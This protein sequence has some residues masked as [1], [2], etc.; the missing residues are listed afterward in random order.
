MVCIMYNSESDNSDDELHH[1]NDTIYLHPENPYVKPYVNSNMIIYNGEPIIADNKIITM[2]KTHIYLAKEIENKSCYIRWIII[3]EILITIPYCYNVYGVFLC[4]FTTIFNT[5]IVC[6]TFNYNKK[7]MKFYI[8]YEIIQLCIKIS[9]SIYITTI[10]HNKAYYNNLH[11][12]NTVNPYFILGS[13]IIFTCSHIPIIY[14]TIN[15]YKI[16]PTTKYI[17]SNSII[18]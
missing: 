15:Y 9:I 7:Y 6:C 14:Y 8:L 5:S 4:L 2:P 17:P 1:L 12:N 13:Q 18:L 10:I 11:I 3:F 16:L